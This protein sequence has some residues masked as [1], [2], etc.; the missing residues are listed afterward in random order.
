MRIISGEKRGLKLITPEGEHTRPTEDRVKENVFN[1]LGQSFYDTEVLDIFSGTG[2]MGIEFLSR[3][4][5]KLTCIENDKKTLKVLKQ[6]LT[7]A[8][9]SAKIMEKDAIS[10]LKEL[11]TQ[12]DFIYMDPPYDNNTLYEE[13]VKIIFENRL[14][15]SQGI[16]T[17]EERTGD[18]HDFSEFFELIKVKKYGSTTVGFWRNK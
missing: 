16:L 3:G 15:K 10:A 17:I 2:Q 7:K 11:N 4:A 9:Y 8:K 1:I 18:N 12:Y 5:A 14:L 6:N 13:A